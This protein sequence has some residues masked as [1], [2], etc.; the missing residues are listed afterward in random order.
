M[1]LWNW[2]GAV[3]WFA[4]HTHAS[5]SVHR[6]YKLWEEGG[7]G[8][9][10]ICAWGFVIA[11]ALEK[12]RQGFCHHVT[13]PSLH[14]LGHCCLRL[15]WRC[16][17]TAYYQPHIM[18]HWRWECHLTHWWTPQKGKKSIP[19]FF[20]HWFFIII[21]RKCTKIVL[22]SS[23][24]YREIGLFVMSQKGTDTLDTSEMLVTIRPARWDSIVFYFFKSP[25]LR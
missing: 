19:L 11:A 9:N 10:K 22:A 4:K 1:A 23:T 18:Q 13:P 3:T 20:F 6:L 17:R 5:T 12:Q 16:A 24:V 2:A 15:H 7:R 8:R 25:S 14:T 21:I